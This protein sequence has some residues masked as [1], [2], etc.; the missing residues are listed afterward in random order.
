[1]KSRTEISLV[2]S[3]S[4]IRTR[5]CIGVPCSTSQAIT[6]TLPSYEK[7]VIIS[8]LIDLFF[9]FLWNLP[10]LLRTSNLHSFFVISTMHSATIAHNLKREMCKT[11]HSAQSSIRTRLWRTCAHDLSWSCRQSYA[12]DN[13]YATELREVSNNINSYWLIF[14]GLWNSITT[15]T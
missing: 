14:L 1:M 6:T 8:I 10:Q 9:L 15:F 13:H 2:I 4:P 3:Q 11:H 5:L 7:L 12:C